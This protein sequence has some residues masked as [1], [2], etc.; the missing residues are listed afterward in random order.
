MITT[1]RNTVITTDTTTKLPQRRESLFQIYPK[2]VQVYSYSD[3]TLLITYTNYRGVLVSSQ[4]TN[5]G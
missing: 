5:M 3:I 1:S 4:L 2:R